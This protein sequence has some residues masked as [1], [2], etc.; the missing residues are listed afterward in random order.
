VLK[1]RID[2]SRFVQLVAANPARIMGLAPQKGDIVVGADADLMIIDP[3]AKSTLSVETLH[4]KVDYTPF[5]GME[6]TGWPST[7]MLRGRILVQDGELVVSK[8]FGSFVQRKL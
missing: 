5:A 2:L 4:Q 3:Q 1:K 6:I 8:G 7:V